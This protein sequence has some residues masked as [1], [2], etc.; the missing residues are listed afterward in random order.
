MAVEVKASERV[1]DRA[2]QGLRAL[3]E[4]VHLRHKIIVSNE[5][6]PW[7][8]EDGIEVLPV[9]VFFRRLWDGDFF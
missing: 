6:R 9:N 1:T 7:R 3:A 8:T 4:E 2:M 5:P